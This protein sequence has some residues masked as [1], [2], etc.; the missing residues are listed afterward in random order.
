MLVIMA[1]QAK[2]FPIAAIW[3]VIVVVVIFVVHGEFM[4]VFPG[5]LPAA[6]G[7]DPGVDPQ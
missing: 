2:V 5:K 3:G 7:A 6:T 1:I 4:Q